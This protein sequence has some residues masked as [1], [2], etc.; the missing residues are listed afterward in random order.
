MDPHW[1]KHLKQPNHFEC[2]GDTILRE[3]HSRLDDLQRTFSTIICF[4][5]SEIRRL[6]LNLENLKAS[7]EFI[8]AAHEDPLECNSTNPKEL[9][10]RHPIERYEDAIRKQLFVLLKERINIYK[11]CGEEMKREA[12]TRVAT[13]IVRDWKAVREKM[14][15]TEAEV[16]RDLGC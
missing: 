14:R 10:E 15:R 16:R 12:A 9:D 1:Q 13:D 4:K 2:I 7:N 8:A 5:D 3:I 11:E 6:K